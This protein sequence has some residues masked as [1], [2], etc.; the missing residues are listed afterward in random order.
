L[1]LGDLSV[2]MEQWRRDKGNAVGEK[3]CGRLKQLLRDYSS[4]A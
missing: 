3:C 4:E 1:L 2:L